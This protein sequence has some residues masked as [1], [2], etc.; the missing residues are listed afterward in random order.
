MDYPLT[1]AVPLPVRQAVQ[2]GQRCCGEQGTVP[3]RYH[4]PRGAL[5]PG[6]KLSLRDLAEMFLT[7]GFVFTYEAVREWEAKLTPALAENLRRKRKGRVGR[8][9]YIDETYIRV[10]GQWRYLY[11]AIDRDGALVDVMLSEHRDWAAAKA[12]FRSATIPERPGPSSAGR[13]DIGRVA[14]LTTDLSRTIA[15]SNADVDRCWD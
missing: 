3:E 7:R 4:R 6:Y 15:A 2:R 1:I 5:A 8:S 9:W 13:C 11:R 10:R 12:F 14:I